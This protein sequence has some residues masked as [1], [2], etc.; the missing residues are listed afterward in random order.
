M[1]LSY[2]SYLC[3]IFN[4]VAVYIGLL[5]HP[6]VDRIDPPKDITSIASTGKLIKQGI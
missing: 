3:S 4:I 5:F 6:L 1:L 2:I